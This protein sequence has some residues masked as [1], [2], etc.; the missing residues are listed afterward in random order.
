MKIAT[1][2][3][4]VQEHLGEAFKELWSVFS[5][6]RPGEAPET[7]V[8]HWSLTASENVRAPKSWSGS[9]KND[10]KGYLVSGVDRGF[11]RLAVTIKPTKGKVWHSAPVKKGIAPPELVGAIEKRTRGGVSGKWQGRLVEIFT[12]LHQKHPGLAEHA[13]IG[14]LVSVSSMVFMLS[15]RHAPL[16]APLWNPYELVPEK[17][18]AI[19]QMLVIERSQQK[20]FLDA[21]PGDELDFGLLRG[22]K[23]E[24]SDIEEFLSL[25]SKYAW[26]IDRN[27]QSKGVPRNARKFKLGEEITSQERKITPAEIVKNAIDMLAD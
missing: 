13:V 14:G 7:T 3:Y 6:Q 5:E 9:A 24:E 1:S 4:C 20:A 10:P 22:Q 19:P 15:D 21:A 26:G 2:F 16:S 17:G 27:G 8:W 23:M 12:P 11:L 25:A 18:I